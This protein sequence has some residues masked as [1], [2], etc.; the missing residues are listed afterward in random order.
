MRSKRQLTEAVFFFF[1]WVLYFIGLAYQGDDRFGIKPSEFVF[2]VNYLLATL[3]INYWLL[4][5]FLYRKRYL[6]FTVLTALVILLAIIVEEFA[7]EPLLLPNTKIAERFLGFFFNLLD[8]GPVLLLFVGFKLAWDNLHQQS[9]LEQA[10]KEKVD[11]Q[12]Q[13]LKSQLN[14]HFLFNNLNNLYSYAQENSPKTQE[15][16]LQLSAILRYMLY[17]SGEKFVPLEKELKYLE[18]FIRLQELQMEDRG[19]VHFVV[20]GS[21]Y[22]K[23]IAPLILITFVEN[24]FKHSL[25]S[26]ADDIRIDIRAVISNHQLVFHCTNTFSESSST[27]DEYLNNGIGLGNVRKRLALLYTERHQLATYPKDGLYVVELELQLL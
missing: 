14:P 24:C 6:L 5:H 7:L 17:E 26:Q 9:R 12:L 1:L 4:P 21:P 13:F 22:G 19:E 10:E 23:R 16:I 15:I 11:S 18:D 20:E 27:A 8:I 2:A 3:L 25:S